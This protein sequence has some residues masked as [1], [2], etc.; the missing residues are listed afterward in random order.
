MSTENLENNNDGTTSINNDNSNI[1]SIDEV[2]ISN[3]SSSTTTT[4]N[5]TTNNNPTV[6]GPRLSQSNMTPPIIPK[7]HES[8]PLSRSQIYLNYRANIPLNKLTVG[9]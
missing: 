3:N 6:S 9:R 7:Y 8:E 1:V 4:N 5:P 2:K